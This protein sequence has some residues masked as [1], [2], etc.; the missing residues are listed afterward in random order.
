MAN[1]DHAS[2][3]QDGAA[4]TGRGG[5][6][7]YT[8]LAVLFAIV[9]SMAGTSGAVQLWSL[10]QQREREVEL[11]FIGAEFRR[12]IRSY[13]EETPGPAKR[14]PAELTDLLKDNRFQVTRRHLRRIYVDPMTAKAEWGLVK[15][16]QGG[17]MGVYSLSERAPIKSAGF[18]LADQ[19][20]A[21]KSKYT[22]WQFAYSP[23][24]PVAQPSGPGRPSTPVPVSPGVPSVGP[25][26]PGR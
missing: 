11:L 25:G 7:G 20:L 22:E 23:Q 18:R 15:S 1:F 3:V 26:N 12:A 10:A 24:L 9:V 21:D 14:Y 6:A 17:I 5:Q 13:Y 19:G 16:P 4:R 8:Y 2:T